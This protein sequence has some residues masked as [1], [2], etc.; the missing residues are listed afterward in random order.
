MEEKE[1]WV[2]LRCLWKDCSWW[3]WWEGEE[4][5]AWPEMLV[6]VVTE[7]SLPER[8]LRLLKGLDRVNPV[9]MMSPGGGR[10]GEESVTQSLSKDARGYEPWKFH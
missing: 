1:S 6:V 10:G 4:P 7:G 3:P 2:P 8:G 9:S 5:E